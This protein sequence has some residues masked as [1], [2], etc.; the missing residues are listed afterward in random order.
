MSHQV[1]ITE[2]IRAAD[3]KVRKLRSSMTTSLII[4]PL[5]LP[6]IVVMEI[7]QGKTL[8]TVDL[9]AC[10]GFVARVKSSWRTRSFAQTSVCG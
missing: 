10:T 8:D 7:F 9:H 5:A 6:A 1:Q 3:E 4:E 2:F